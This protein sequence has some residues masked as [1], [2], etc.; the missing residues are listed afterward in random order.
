MTLDLV[1]KAEEEVLAEG[2]RN[3]APSRMLLQ[4]MSSENNTIN[5]LEKDLVVFLQ[6]LRV[7][8]KEKWPD[9]YYPGYIQQFSIYPFYLTLFTGK[10][11]CFLNLNNYHALSMV[12]LWPF[13]RFCC[14]K[15]TVIGTA[16]ENWKRE[17]FI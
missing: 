3:A 9:R 7:E 13:F 14:R 8:L 11:L 10:Y 6:K 15:M 5:D 2:N 12:F 1:G 4:K 17:H 16:R